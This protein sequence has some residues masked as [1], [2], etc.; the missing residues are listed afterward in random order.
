MDLFDSE[1]PWVLMKDGSFKGVFNFLPLDMRVGAW[2]LIS[3]LVAFCGL[4]SAAM[5]FTVARSTSLA[6][7]DVDGVT[8][9]SWKEQLMADGAYEAFT[10]SW[11]FNIMGFVWTV[12]IALHIICF[13]PAGFGAW[14]TYT[15]HSWTGMMCRFGLAIVAPFSPTAALVAETLRFYV[16]FSASA[17]FFVWNFVIMP[18]TIFLMPKGNEMRQ[19]FIGYMFNFRLVQLHVCNIFYAIIN[20]VI[21]EPQRQIGPVDF[22]IGVFHFMTYFALYYLVLD[23]LGVHLYPIFTPRKAKVVIMWALL[24]GLYLGLYGFWGWVLDDERPRYF[25]VIM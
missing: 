14:V 4:Y 2:R 20:G 21:T 18:F 8:N 5:G 19:R 9:T 17:T 11:Y 10:L 1:Q 6:S 16:L 24:L 12:Y 15:V 22:W 7:V 23:R 25:V 3:F 13:S